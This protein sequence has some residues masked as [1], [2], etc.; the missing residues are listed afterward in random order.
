VTLPDDVKIT[1]Y[2]AIKGDISLGDFE[3]WLYSDRELEKRRN[4]TLCL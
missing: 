4:G 2:K 3:Q 1:F